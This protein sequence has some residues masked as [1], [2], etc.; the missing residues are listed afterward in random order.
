MATFTLTDLK[1]SVDT[2]YAPT[3]VKNGKTEYRL[4]PLLRLT[5]TKRDSVLELTERFD[6]DSDLDDQL[7]TVAEIIR[8]VEVNSKGDELLEL[9]GGDAAMVLELGLTWMSG[10]ELGEAV[11][12]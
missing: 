12:S 2:K 6:A 4:D 11:P 8:T 9:L 7:E 10:S 3:I 5:K 1:K